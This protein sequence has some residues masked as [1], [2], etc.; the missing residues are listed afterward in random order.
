MHQITQTEIPNAIHTSTVNVNVFNILLKDNYGIL[1]FM[2]VSDEDMGVQE[3]AVIRV[4]E[5]KAI[6]SFTLYFLPAL[7]HF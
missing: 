7:L 2:K 1:K 4:E 3:E 6:A 5:Y